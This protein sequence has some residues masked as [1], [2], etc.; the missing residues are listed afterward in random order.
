MT[1]T[2][3]SPRA[4]KEMVLH[5]EVRR[6][7]SHLYR[8][9]K[10]MKQ[11]FA[12]T[13]RLSSVA[14]AVVLVCCS[15]PVAADSGVIVKD[16][17]CEYRSNPLGIDVAKPRLGWILESDQRDQRQTAYRILV[18]SSEA[19]LKVDA[20]DLWD[21]GKVESDQSIQVVYAGKEL[22]SGMECYWKIRVWDRDGRPY[23][24]SEPAMWT[25]GLLHPSDWHGSWIGLDEGKA[26]SELDSSH[27]IWFPEGNP[28]VSAPCAT[29]YF[30]RPVTI[31]EGRKIKSARCLFAADNEFTLRVNGR[32][33]AKGTDY[34]RA[35]AS[36]VTSLLHPGQN[37]LAVAATNVGGADNPAGLIGTV[38]IEFEQGDPITIAA[39]QQ[40]RVSNKKVSGWLDSDFDDSAWRL[41]QVLGDYGM[42]PWGEIAT[43]EVTR[44]SARMLRHEFT[45]E[46]EVRRAAAYVCGLGLFELYLNGKKI[47]DHVL[48]PGLTDYTK[49]AFYVTFDV[50]QNLR[51]G[52]N[53]IGVM[54]GNGRYFAP[55]TNVPIET[56]T[57]GY[58]K[59]LLELRTEYADGTTQTVVS[60]D[61]WRLTTDG[62]IRANNEYDGEEYD[63]RKEIP[64]WIEPG[65]D[66]SG[67][68]KASA[69][70]GPSGVL[71]AQMIEPIRVTETLKPAAITNP[72]PGVY[73]LDMG[74]NIVGWCRLTVSGPR[75]TE[76]T[77]R[78][79]EV[80]RDDGTLYLDNIRSA[81][82]TDRYLL[83]GDGVEV[84][85]P[86]FTYHGFRYVE[87]TGF[88]G[89]PT[90]SA[91]EGRV[92]H[93]AVEPVGTFECSNPLINR[94]YHNIVWGVRGNYRSVPTDCPQRDER[95]GWLGDRSAESKGETYL[96]DVAQLYSKWMTDIQDAQRDSGS[97][98]D[99]APA[100]WPIYSDN[101]TWPSS[102]IIISGMIYDQYGDRRILET[103]YSS[104]KRWIDY[105][106]GFLTNHIMPRDEYGDWCVPP[107]SQKLIHSKD[108][109]RKTAKE[110][111]GT[112][113]FYHDLCLMARYATILGKTEDAKQFNALAKT[114]KQSFSEQFFNPE[115]HLYS[116][117]TQTSCVL[118][119][120]FGM[121]PEGHKEAL[122]A[123]LVDKIMIESDGHIG[124]GLVGGQWLMRVLSDNGRADVAYT[125]AAQTTYPSWGYM[126]GKGATTVWELWNG[127]TADPGMNSHNHL[128]LVGDLGIWFFEYLAGVKCAPD[129][130]G[131]RN[132]RIAPH[133]VSDLTYVDASVKTIRGS[134]ASRWSKV[135]DSF[136]LDVTI[137]ANSDAE[138]SIPKLNW[139]QIAIKE[140]GRVVWEKRHYV[141]GVPGIHAGR[142]ADGWITL[143]V[144]SGSYKFVAT[145]TIDSSRAD[146]ALKYV[147]LLDRIVARQS[148]FIV[149]FLP[150][151][152]VTLERFC[153][154]LGNLF[155]LRARH[156][157]DP[158]AVRYD[159]IARFD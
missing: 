142:D 15:F 105:M 43:T 100:Y 17:R 2:L 46:K 108:P 49:R 104:M 95:Q 141:G 90:L 86:R 129:S 51:Q 96:F 83:K 52:R 133:V 76:V 67:W 131:F 85:E 153:S 41:A 68:Q 25:M 61:G 81:K 127:D 155:C 114:V 158:I 112:A 10:S 69:V 139:K 33:V 64:G 124:T 117:G 72:K 26:R 88:P 34:H 11:T 38:R 122:F 157:D 23:A 22:L 91:I 125:I 113:Y 36:D 70:Q 16:L 154:V 121:V 89:E 135:D 71:A 132:I 63:A 66:D 48:E 20:G 55:R 47:G 84:Y 109:K 116:N 3:M 145:L 75:G 140:S 35:V 4:M 150:P 98:P 103:Q 12:E 44:L 136:T 152:F 111:L 21:T 1:R 54:L 147:L 144:G 74:Q 87:L 130:P 73:V 82:A 151:G 138:I 93:D 94:I 115:T 65:F 137:P 32:V 134:V 101:I 7:L 45:V 59:L 14:V 97:I 42:A 143:D 6:V 27:W 28:A 57:F 78:H 128:M 126:T 5:T 56:R 119:L 13:K 146:S 80:L 39:D 106:R 62:P 148:E 118:P 50:T 92:V 37:T 9:G 60:S 156:N 40:W 102:Y 99:V 58:P 29:R 77:L 18:A 159:Y 30:R 31:P 53:A 120:A 24:W 79:A 123:R 107:E 149:Q 19:K 110:V 8:G